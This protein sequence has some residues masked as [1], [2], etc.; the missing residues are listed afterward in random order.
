MLLSA[1]VEEALVMAKARVLVSPSTQT[2]NVV[3]KAKSVTSIP[4]KVRFECSHL[5]WREDRRKER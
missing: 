5:R 3:P 2:E 1:A 4:E